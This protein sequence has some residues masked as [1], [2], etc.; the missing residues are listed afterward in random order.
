MFPLELNVSSIQHFSTGDGPGIRTTVFL[1]GCPLRCP[2]CHNPETWLPES[3][4]LV[5][6]H[7]GKTVT[8]GRRMT[9][10]AVAAEVLSDREFYVASGGG[11][12]VSGGEPLWQAQQ[13]AALAARMQA[14]GVPVIVDTAGDV[15]FEAF[16]C[17][18]LYTDAYFVDLKAACEEDY[19]KL[20][21]NF[22]RIMQNLRRL[23]ER[24]G[25]VRIRI[26][27]IPVW[28]TAPEYITR[29]KR[30]LQE[31]AVEEVDLLP[32]HRLGSSKYA[33]L[34]QVYPYGDTPPL[35][36]EE[37]ELIAENYRTD[38]VVRVEK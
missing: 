13:V 15:P 14:Q 8:Y 27:L 33:A 37:V 28:D 2:W 19:Q 5:F 25:V 38:F 18:L 31:L 17:T 26:P 29:M 30:L 23:R 36:P 3:Q 1:K 11:L 6:P 20:G 24:G 35:T 7:G 34:G 21:G 22:P 4:T 16:E 12:T 10:E 9:V 32:F